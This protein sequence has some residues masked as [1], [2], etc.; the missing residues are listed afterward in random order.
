MD[1]LQRS[2]FP[3][4]RKLKLQLG[5]SVYESLLKDRAHI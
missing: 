5:A 4:E 1:I 2:R 3:E